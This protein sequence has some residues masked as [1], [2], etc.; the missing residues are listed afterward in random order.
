[1]PI[2]EQAGT[3]IMQFDRNKLKAAVLYACSKCDPSRLG[4]VK[5]HK[6][7]YFVDMLYYAN[8]Q[9]PVTGATYRKRPLGPTCDQLLPLLREL[10]RAGALE[11]REVDYFGYRKKEY[12]ALVAPEA[13]RFNSL[14]LELLDEVIDFV[15]ND[16]T[17]RTISDY[18]HNRAWEIA[19]FGD[20][21]PYHSAYHL[22]PSDLSEETMAWADG[23]ARKLE[24]MR[25][26][27]VAVDFAPFRVF[28]AGVL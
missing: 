3:R 11:V 21:I 24:Q 19:E 22:F 20:E 7:L 10:E 4:A 14:E 15:C 1:M 12:R 6:V 26:E 5:L 18:S 13:A 16:N 28:R 8:K 2:R 17:A 23:E 25:T 27:G 9:T